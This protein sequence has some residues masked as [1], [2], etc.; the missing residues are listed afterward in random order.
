VAGD[1]EGEA[2]P[3]VPTRRRLADPR[4]QEGAVFDEVAR[5]YDEARPRYPAEVFDELGRRCGLG[6]ESRVLEIGCGTGQ[7]TRNL[8]ATGAQVRCLEPGVAL[9]GLARHNLA[10][11]PN[12]TVETTTFE[13]ADESPGTYDI[14]FSATAFHW[15]DPSVSFVKAA[16]VL[17]PG[18]WLALL[19]NLHSAGGTHTS[20]RIAEPIRDLHRRL[21]PEVGDWTFPTDEEIRERAQAGGDIAAVWARIERKLGPPPTVDRLFEPPTVFTYP[22]LARYDRDGYLTMLATQSSYALMDPEWRGRLLDAIGRLVDE[23]LG[24]VITKQYVTVLAIARR[25]AAAPA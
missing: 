6:R 3:F 20:E 14:A 17:R 16:R 7:A 19:T 21:A 2:E 9:G 22:W 5:L 8:A 23:C 15:I 25:R 1:A 13:A 4:A 12:V 18:G 24:G 10:D 11:A